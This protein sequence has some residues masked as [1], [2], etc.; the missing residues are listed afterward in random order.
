MMI[1]PVEIDNGQ[2]LSTV[3]GKFLKLGFSLISDRYKAIFMYHSGDPCLQGLNI[4]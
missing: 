4:Y 1:G 3:L 2:D